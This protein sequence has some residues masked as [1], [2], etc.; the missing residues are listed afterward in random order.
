M[1]CLSTNN[2]GTGRG[3]VLWVTLRP[4]LFWHWP[5]FSA[6][7]NQQH[8]NNP[9]MLLGVF[10]ALCESHIQLYA[11]CKLPMRISLGAV[12]I[13]KDEKILDVSFL[14]SAAQLFA[15][16]L[17]RLGF[18]CVS[19]LRAKVSVPTGKKDKNIFRFT[20]KKAKLCYLRV[21]LHGLLYVHANII[22]W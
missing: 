13:W 16:V 7:L 1:L 10:L 18:H 12:E 5:L 14:I 22:S 11:K 20:S 4:D 19:N 6:C 15:G 9:L 17:H 21:H 8:C 3:V 2:L